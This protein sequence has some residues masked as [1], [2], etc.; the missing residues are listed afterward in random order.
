[1]NKLLRL[2]FIYFFVLCFFIASFVQ[3]KIKLGSFSDLTLNPDFLLVV[4]YYVSDYGK[5]KAGTAFF[6]ASGFVRLVK[7]FPDKVNFIPVNSYAVI[8]NTNKYL[9]FVT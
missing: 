9:V 4:V 5:S 3:S 1:M 7:S 2:L 6:F 8:L